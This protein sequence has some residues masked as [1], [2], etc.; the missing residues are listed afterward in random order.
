MGYVRSLA[1]VLVL[2][3]C[4][5]RST[6]DDSDGGTGSL[7]GLVSL[8]VKPAD[9]TLVITQGVAATSTYTAL[10]TFDDGRIE[11]VTALVQFALDDGALGGFAA[12][13]LTTTTARGGQTQVR[14][15]ANTGVEG[16]TGLTVRL[17]QTWSDPGSTLPADPAGLF[18][19]TVDPA[20]APSL[21]YPNDG[22]M[23]PPNLGLLELHFRPGTNNTLFELSLQNT[24]LDLTIYL[25][26]TLPMNGGCIYLP[27]PQVWSWL[28]E[29]N[30]GGEP[31][32]WSFRGTDD[33]GTA[34][35]ASTPMTLRFNLEDL[36]GGIYY[37]TTTLR[38][39]MRYD[40]AS[41]TQTVAEKFIGTEMT[42]GTCMGCHA[43][44]RDGTKMVA[45][46][47]GQNDGRL[48]LLDVATKTPLVPYAST[49]KSIFESWN[50]DN[51]AFVGVYGDNGATNF[52]LMVFDGSSGAV[53]ETI[54]A[55]G[56]FDN[57]TNHPDW[58][59]MGDRI[60]F[61]NVGVRNTLQKMY[62]S[63][64]R[65]VTKTGGAWQPFEVIVP[66]AAGKNRYY[67]AWAPDGKLLVFNE[68][69]C[70]TGNT[71]TECNGDT[72]PSAKLHAVDGVAGG[73]VTVLERANAPG[74]ADNG[75]L[76]L[77][78]SFPKWNPYVFARDRTGGRVGWLTFSSARKY[79]LRNPPG[80][81]TLLWMVAVD[82]DAPAGTDPSFPAFAL[83]FQDLTTSNHIAQW[84]TKVVG[85]I[86]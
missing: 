44:S 51:T 9:Q 1:V 7:E 28:A 23:L 17:A 5:T 54:P 61:A 18:T 20:R 26:C 34:V 45:E 32:T 60:A 36:T 15:L 48:L 39:I 22:V 50:H 70:T 25:R 21:V 49:E 4:G 84:T 16:A 24:V 47:G 37:W 2:V 29:S 85:P 41:S 68:S 72:N 27:D 67:P 8:T 62:N 82:L 13:D 79:G 65:T 57:P 75:A 6:G 38:A 76:D 35:G 80:N 31:V 69:T 14:A 3:G 56:S 64:I 52:D 63:E 42:N 58:S 40:F 83:P 78:N 77:T 55:G 12:A 59:P 53:T 19:G 86:Q 74:V 30:R 71:G 66:R 43:L 11:D 81:G 10:G 33:T 46:S 73:A